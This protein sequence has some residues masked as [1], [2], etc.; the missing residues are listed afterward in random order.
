MTVEYCPYDFQIAMGQTKLNEL[1]S[2]AVIHL[3]LQAEQAAIR[4]DSNVVLWSEA[5]LQ[6]GH[7]I[8]I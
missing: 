7:F 6:T 5:A 8:V 3:P 1:Q 2:V 4:R